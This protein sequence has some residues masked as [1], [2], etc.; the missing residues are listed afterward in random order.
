M[1]NMGVCL[2]V[3]TDLALSWYLVSV[4]DN[5]F[6]HGNIF[7]YFPQDSNGKLADHAAA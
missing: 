3:L 4:V 1:P 2:Q 5:D 6:V 7:Q